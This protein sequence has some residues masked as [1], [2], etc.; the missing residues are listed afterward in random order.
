MVLQPKKTKTIEL[1]ISKA[2]ASAFS[3]ITK[4]PLFNEFDIWKPYDDSHPQDLNLY[5]VGAKGKATLLFNKTYNIMFGCVLL[6][7]DIQHVEI[8]A[9]KKPSSMIVVDYKKILLDLYSQRAQLK[10]RREYSRQEDHC[11]HQLWFV[12]EV[13]H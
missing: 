3:K 1:D 9:F 8:L 2:Y 10:L 13:L 6:K 5:I 12:G 7:V 4:I 11:Q